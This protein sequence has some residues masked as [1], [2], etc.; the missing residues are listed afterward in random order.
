MLIEQLDE[1]VRQRIGERVRQRIG[2]VRQMD[3]MEISI[4]PA[5]F[6]EDGAG[7]LAYYLKHPPRC[8]SGFTLRPVTLSDVSWDGHASPSQL[9]TTVEG[10]QIEG[11][12]HVNPV[13]WLH[14]TCGCD[15][16]LVLGHY[17]RNPDYHD[18]LVFVSPLALTCCACGKVTE[19][20][21]S[22]NHGYDAEI[23][24]IASNHRGTGK[25][26]E[27]ACKRCGPQGFQLFAR[28]EYPDDRLAQSGDEF[29]GREQD[30]FSWF[31]LVGK[32]SACGHFMRI[33]DC[34]CA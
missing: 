16:H 2:K 7:Q 12:E 23:G 15:S 20:F 29:R 6:T 13:F 30:L 8:V 24:A 10:V 18:F 4:Q 11:T 22:D 31:S 5:E 17:W 32:C 3:E 1:R 28:F 14:C 27:F 19:L 34:E 26:S 25:R 9:N 21:D 33:A